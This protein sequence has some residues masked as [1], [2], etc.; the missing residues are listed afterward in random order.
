M[1]EYEERLVAQKELRDAMLHEASVAAST[2]RNQGNQTDNAQGD[3]SSSAMD[4]GDES[5]VTSDTVPV[6]SIYY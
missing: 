6:C 5:S 1:K 3:V 4:Q 2:Q